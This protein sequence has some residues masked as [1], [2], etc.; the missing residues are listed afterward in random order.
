MGSIAKAKD[1]VLEAMMVGDLAVSGGGESSR[2]PSKKDM[3]ELAGE[4]GSM[5]IRWRETYYEERKTIPQ[6]QLQELKGA[7]PVRYEMDVRKSR[8]EEGGGGEGLLLYPQC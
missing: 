7:E 5:D 2:R 8:G 1:G 6:P 4:T 3:C